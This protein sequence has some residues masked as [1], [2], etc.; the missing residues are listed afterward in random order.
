M[1]ST[2]QPCPH[3][4]LF[5]AIEN[6]FRFEFPASIATELTKYLDELQ[7]QS[8]S[9]IVGEWI[10][11]LPFQKRMMVNMQLTGERNK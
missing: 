1:I 3:S 6:G 5:F 11:Q 4:N 10:L 9:P 2:I 8:D 7:K